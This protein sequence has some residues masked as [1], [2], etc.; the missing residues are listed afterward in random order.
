MNIME[1]KET[2]KEVFVPVE[3]P[4]VEPRM[5][6]RTVVFAI[7]ILNAILAMFSVSPVEVD[8]EALYN[9]VSAIFLL[10][11]GF[12]AWSKNNDYSKKARK[13]KTI[14]EQV[15]KED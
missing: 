2:K 13:R 15:E 3:A 10:V 7:A 5:V 6:V 8:Q 12:E 9:F 4:R 11:S 14:I 1:E